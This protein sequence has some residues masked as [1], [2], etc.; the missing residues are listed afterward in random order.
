MGKKK[1][2]KGKVDPI[3]AFHISDN[4]PQADQF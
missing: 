2:K 3:W 1:K 4:S